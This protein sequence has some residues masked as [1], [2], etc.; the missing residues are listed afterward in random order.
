[1]RVLLLFYLSPLWTLLLARLLLDERPGRRGLFVIG[2]SL[3]GAFVMLWRP[4]LG[5]PLPQ[6]RAEWL[7]F[8]AGICFAL[9]NVL[10]RRARHLTLEAKSFSV[11]FGVF[12]LSLVLMSISDSPAMPMAEVISQHWGVILMLGIIL[13]VTTLLVQY[14]VTHTPVTRASV[15]FIFELVVAAISSWFLAGEVM[16]AREWMGGTMIVAATIFAPHDSD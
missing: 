12:V 7:A 10:T 2:L 6:N 14:G 4:E 9:T 15:I 8:S 1:M 3:A 11:W 13:L 16:T 5:L